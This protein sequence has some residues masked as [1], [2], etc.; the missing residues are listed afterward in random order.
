[1]HFVTWNNAAAA[2]AAAVAVMI[3]L[4]V[5]PQVPVRSGAVV[6]KDVADH[7]IIL[8]GGAH[9][10]VDVFAGGVGRGVGCNGALEAVS[11]P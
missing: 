10:S 4:C 1:M 5:C 11:G 9:A 7:H 2:A 8:R 3:R 6:A